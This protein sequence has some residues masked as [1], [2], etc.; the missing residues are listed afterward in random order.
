MTL[1]PL[2]SAPSIIQVHA[3]LAGCA[4]LLGAAQLWLPKGTLTHRVLG[5]LW[6]TLIAGVA[7][8]SF[9][10]SR[11]Q[12]SFGPFSWIHGLSIFTLAVIPVAIL[13]ARRGRISRHA[14]TM[15]GLYIGALVIAGLFTFAPG[16]IMNRA[17][18][19]G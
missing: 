14:R 4:L 13:S 1:G 10:I 15:T 8:G 18:F 3:T 16:R 9:W 2:L 6:S 12:F 5:W 17:L 11:E 19:G 7:L